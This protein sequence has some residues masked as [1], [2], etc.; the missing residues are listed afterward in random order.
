M[1]TEPDV[2]SYHPNKL[3]ILSLNAQSL[4]SKIDDLRVECLAHGYDIIVSETWLSS[5]IVDLE[6]SIPGYTVARRVRDR[7]G[8][9]LAIYF[10]SRI[11]YTLLSS[12]YPDLELLLFEC[13]M[14]SRPLT[15]CSIYRPPNSSPGYLTKFHFT[16]TSLSSSNLENLIICGDFNILM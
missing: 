9:G 5:Q 11:S 8:G 15:I 1:N 16:L 14:Y 12:L 6:I 3:S 10:N 13:H 4:L 2:L 7:H